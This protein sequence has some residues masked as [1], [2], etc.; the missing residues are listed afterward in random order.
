MFWSAVH[1]LV[2]AIEGAIHIQDDVPPGIQ[3]PDLHT[4]FAARLPAVCKGPLRRG[5]R[6][7]VVIP[8]A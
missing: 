6:R 5:V 2:A 1:L 8:H 7:A 3:D 4:V